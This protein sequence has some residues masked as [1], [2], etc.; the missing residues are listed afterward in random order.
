[1]RALITGGGGFIARHLA[2]E[3]RDGGY[4]VVLFGMERPPSDALSF[5]RGDI[6]HIE[7]LLAAARGADVLFHL[8]GA[9]GTEYLVERA[10]EAVDVNINGTLNVYE[11]ARRL[12]I[13]VVDVGVI[14]NWPSPYMITKKAAAS[15]GYMY[16]RAFGTDVRILEL[17]HVYGP[18]QRVEPYF[19]A[20]PTFIT[21]ALRNEPLTIFGRGRRL[22]D[23]LFVEDAARGLRLTGECSALSGRSVTL[24][25]GRVITV[26][27]LA[28]LVIRLTESRSPIEFAPMRMGEPDDITEDA[29]GAV[30]LAHWE[31]MFS[32][33]PCTRLQD[34]LKKT[35]EYYRA[36]I[37]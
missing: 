26:L 2:S 6:R 22:M 17:S 25:T 18:G 28:Q 35:I 7:E 36:T 37:V 12:E 16:H 23:C 32:W 29:A 21:R 20:V 13:A 1:M 19:K 8:A 30:D 34:G 9:I 11:V 33:R 15:F 5:V 4:D 24:G 10:H 14:P 31:S 3:L 27:G